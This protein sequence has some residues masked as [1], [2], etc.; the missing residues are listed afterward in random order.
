VSGCESDNALRVRLDGKDLRWTSSGLLDRS[1]FTFDDFD[2]GF[3]AGSHTLEFELGTPPSPGNPIRQLC[4]L[5]LHEYAAEPEFHWSNAWYVTALPSSRVSVAHIWR[6]GVWWGLESHS[7]SRPA[8]LCKGVCLPYLVE[9]W[10]KD[11]PPDQRTLPDAQYELA[12]FL[13]SV[14]GRAMDAVFLQD[15]TD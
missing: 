14:S 8:R 13:S 3:T 1:F 10:E 7:A 5:T 12:S 9:F 6:F 4:S 11:I 2:Q 15:L